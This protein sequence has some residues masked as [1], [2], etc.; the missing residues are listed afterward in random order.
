MTL[1]SARRRAFWVISRVGL[2]LYRRF[3]VFGTLRA[4]LAVIEQNGRVL[5]IRRNDGRGFSFPGGLAMPWESELETLEREVAEETGLCVTACERTLQYHSA[6]DIPCK[7][8]VFRV[9]AIGELR[10]SW[11]GQPEWVTLTELRSG[12]IASQSAIVQKM[13]SSATCPL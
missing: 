6:A 12:I 1:Q 8:S 4:S 11:E 13:E 2:R 7:I 9:N 5:A 10:D 3:P